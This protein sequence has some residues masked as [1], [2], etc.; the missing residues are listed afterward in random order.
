MLFH[1]DLGKVLFKF[2]VRY[3]FIAVVMNG[4]GYS[5][6]KGQMFMCGIWIE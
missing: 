4:R 5:W 6:E 1:S 2:S 3:T